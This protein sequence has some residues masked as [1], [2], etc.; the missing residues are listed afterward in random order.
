[1]ISKRMTRQSKQR[2]GR[3]NKPANTLGIGTISVKLPTFMPVGTRG[4]VKGLSVEQVASTGVKILLG[5]TYHLHLSPGE[6]VVERLG[7]LAKMNKWSG[8]TLTDS[9]GFQVFSLGKINKITDEGVSF[10]NPKNGD[11]IMLTPE[12]SMRIQHKLGADIIMAFDDVV[13]LSKT[14]RTRSK[15]AME[16]T[17]QWLERSIEEHKKIKGENK[18]RKPKLFGI[19]QGGLNKADRLK[20]LKF[21]QNTEVDGIAIGGLAVGE[22]RAEMYKMLDYLKGYYDSSRPRYLMGV[23]HPTDMRHAIERGIDMFDSVLPTRNGRHGSF[24]IEVKAKDEQYSINNA[25]FASDDGPLQKGCDCTTCQAGYARSYLR[26]LVKS[27][28]TLGGSLI[29]IHNIRYLQRICE[30]YQGKR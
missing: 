5:N 21:V 1:M 13:G 12:K 4:A 15:E 16:R 8:A 18:T 10:Q 6:E 25:Q 26:H 27:G 29:S 9:G 23:G 17:H 22:S 24:F 14:A 20:S 3:D 19:V 30:S 7:G 28:E 11:S 2:S